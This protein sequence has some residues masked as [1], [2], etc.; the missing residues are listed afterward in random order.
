M[1]TA[2]ILELFKLTCTCLKLFSQFKSKFWGGCIFSF[3]FLGRWVCACAC[4]NFQNQHSHS[5]ILYRH[6]IIWRW[7]YINL[8]NVCMCLSHVYQNQSKPK[9]V[10]INKR[11]NRINDD[12][13]DTSLRFNIGISHR[14]NSHF[15][16]NS[17]ILCDK[18]RVFLPVH[19]AIYL[20]LLYVAAESLRHFKCALI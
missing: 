2:Y 14:D 11:L 18:D 19:K 12:P 10:R 20:Y 15:S 1:A 8:S 7:Y 16:E 17:S 13:F 4:E 3:P 9:K 5:N 6:D